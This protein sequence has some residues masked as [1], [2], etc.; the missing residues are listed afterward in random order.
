MSGKI[1]GLIWSWLPDLLTNKFNTISVE[2]ARTQF[3][4]KLGNKA[5][6]NRAGKNPSQPEKFGQY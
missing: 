1:G 5:A 3:C 4:H 2:I 6:E